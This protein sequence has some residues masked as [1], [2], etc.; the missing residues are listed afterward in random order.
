MDYLDR[1]R[2]KA[3]TAATVWVYL[4]RVRSWYVDGTLLR[5]TTLGQGCLAPA[6][7]NQFY[8]CPEAL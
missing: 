6:L 8:D 3:P 1:R 2:S 4:V 5:A 7:G